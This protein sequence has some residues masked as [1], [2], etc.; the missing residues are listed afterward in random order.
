[1]L[2]LKLLGAVTLLGAACAYAFFYRKR[3]R[4]GVLYVHAW[5]SFLL[6]LRHRLH[7][8]A[9]PVCEV[10]DTME[11]S[12][13]AAL[14]G[15]DIAG[16]EDSF[17]ALC[18]RGSALFSG[19]CALRLCALADALEQ[20]VSCP[21]AVEAIDGVLEALEKQEKESNDFLQQATRTVAALCI[22]GAMGLILLLW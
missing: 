6:E 14:L 21:H 20:A 1:M 19:D 5:Q 2:M 10:V 9:L 16:A 13:R 8:C 4:Q 18:R 17:E 7:T 11:A 3:A 15:E 22:C 12:R